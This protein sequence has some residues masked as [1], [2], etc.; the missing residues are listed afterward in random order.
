M[1][2]K[3]NKPP[4]NA[5]PKKNLLLPLTL[6]L[7]VLAAGA[8]FIHPAASAKAGA[9]LSYIGKIAAAVSQNSPKNGE[10]L[11][12]EYESDAVM[13]FIRNNL[14]SKFNALEVREADYSITYVP[15][16]SA[17]A[18][19]AA[20]PRGRPMEWVVWELA[21]A[22]NGTA[23]H[24]DDCACPSETRCDISFK[25]SGARHPKVYLK[26]TRSN[27]Y[28][29]NTAKMAILIENFGF[30]ANSTT[31][32]FLAF[33][34][35]LTVSLVPAQKL[36][37][38]TAQIADEYNKEIVLALPMEPLPAQFN[39]YRSSM[40]KIN[41]EREEIRELLARADAAIP[42]FSGVSNFYGN[43]TRGIMEDTRAMDLVLGEIKRH[44]RPLYFVYTDD[45]KKSVAPQRMAAAKVP[46]MRV[47]RT[48]N[49]GLSKEQMREK[50]SDAAT[51][52]QKTG[53][54]LLKAQPSQEFITA[55][56]EE[57]ETLKRN[58]VRLVYV[59]DLAK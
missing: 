42:N 14:V 10:I 34:E 45:A 56:K 20:V 16:D 52:A 29:A 55:L 24:M 3:K 21:S 15:K 25:S 19:S 17:F 31:T 2:N 30:E 26:V 46:G 48:I 23:Y 8:V 53:S 58:G 5:P 18:C 22:A 43:G 32:E 36:A 35:P 57:S 7:A 38:W 41:H 40:I 47:E 33:P 11:G 50:L 27:R 12:I 28:I 49:A 4:K 54:I 44:K 13:K 37:T 9:A 39:S 1:L 59:S 51:A 6:V